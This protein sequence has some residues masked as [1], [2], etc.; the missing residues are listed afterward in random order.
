MIYKFIYTNI[1]KKSSQLAF[2]T[3]TNKKIIWN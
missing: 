2:I 3:D 1:T